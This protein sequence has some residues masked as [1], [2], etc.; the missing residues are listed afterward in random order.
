MPRGKIFVLEGTDKSGKNTQSRL[1]VQRLRQEFGR[2]ETI[3]FP[4]YNTPTGR[5]VG[6]CY[7]GKDLG[8]G[9]RAWFGDANSV[10]ARIASGYY[11]LD[12]LAAVPE[13]ERILASGS[14]LVLD[15]WVES[16]MGHQGGKAK[17]SKERNE[18]I[19]Y[20]NDLEYRTLRLPKPDTVIFLYMPYQIAMNLPR[21][22]KADGHESNP[23]H[24]RNAE[25]TYLYLANK[26]RWKK[27]NCAPRGKL[28]DRKDIHNE[29]F[30]IVKPYLSI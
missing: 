26:F 20:I 18:I 6:Q 23:E 17:N 28:R 29:V 2:C 24:L 25:K 15:R 19:K 27:I 16:N 30:E 13:I 5:I 4:R 1:L 10:L 14:N 8:P 3:S 22:E 12:R 11:A 9:D 7:L 21:A